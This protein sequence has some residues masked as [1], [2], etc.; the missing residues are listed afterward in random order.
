MCRFT[1]CFFQF[2]LIAVLIVPAIA[3]ADSIQTDVPEKISLSTKVPVS[4]YG[5]IL[6]EFLYSDSQLSSFGTLNNTPANYN[7]NITGFNRVQ[8]ET[9]QG[10]NDAFISATPQ[11]TRFGFML[12]PY[13]FNGKNFKVDADLEM[14]FFSTANLGAGSIAPRLRR[15]YAGIGQE[16]WHVLIGQEWELF[17]PLNTDTFNIGSNLWNQGNLGNR[18]PQI[19]FTFKQ[20]FGEKSGVEAA[21]SV[22]LPSNSLSS[23]DTANTT[24]IPMGQGRLGVWHDMSEGKFWAYISAAYYRNRNAAAGGADINNWGIA[25]SITAP[26]H[27]FFKPSV[28]FQYGY[29]MGTLFAISSNTA[30]QREIAGWGQVKS[31][32]ASW[33]ET[34][35]GYGGDFLKSSQ[36]AAGSVKNNQIVFAN[37]RFKPIKDF[38]IGP[39]Y[40]F[41][42]TN[43]QG[44]GASKANVV[45]LNAMYYF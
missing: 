10:M 16:R 29:S 39:E 8:D 37:L 7:T 36:V 11:N 6:A 33:F 40:N 23:N 14:D 45:F 5:F 12:A 18:R 28:E 42:S 13:D 21:A 1:R 2:A 3:R 31:Q 32:W 24:G 25:A 41:M 38:I 22:S 20:P 19:Q 26:V 17:S 27:K 4:L 44:S 9:V 35:V 15:A 34:N 43:Y 30:R